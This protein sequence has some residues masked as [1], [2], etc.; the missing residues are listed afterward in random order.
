GLSC[1]PS[2]F[3]TIAVGQT[4]NAFATASYTTRQPCQTFSDTVR[5]TSATGATSGASACAAAS[6]VCSANASVTVVP[7][8]VTCAITL[9]AGTIALSGNGTDHVVLPA[10][11]VNAPIQATITINYPSAVY[12]S[13]LV[14]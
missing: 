3:A 6:S 5:V 14:T 7:I 2:S 4:V 10:D 1:S 11:Q 8:S 9:D 12:L 13:V